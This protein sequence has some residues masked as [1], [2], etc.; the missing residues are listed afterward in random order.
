[1]LPTTTGEP[2]AYQTAWPD[3]HLAARARRSTDV[4]LLSARYGFRKAVKK[5]LKSYGDRLR[6][7]LFTD[8]ADEASTVFLLSSG[9]SGST[10]LSEMLQS[11]PSTRTIFEPF[12]ATRGYPAL[13]DHRYRY[14]PPGQEDAPLRETLSDVLAGRQRSAW[15]DQFNPLMPTTFRRRLVKEV[16]ANLLSPWLTRALPAARFLFLVRHPIP[17]AL[18]QLK[19]GWVLSSQRLR[20]QAELAD[21]YGLDR[22]SRF[23]WPTKGFES[24]VLFWAIENLVALDCAERSGSLLVRY[25]DLVLRPGASLAT[26]GQHIGVEFPDQVR[27]TFSETSWSS[28][29]GVGELSPAEKVNRWQRVASPSQ[30][31]FVGAVLTASELGGL[32]A[33][34]GVDV[35]AR[36][37]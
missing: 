37:V 22:F 34:D 23:G 12:H 35:T 28:R 11:V 19:G 29:R 7:R 26:I 6:S 31:D 14:L 13:A 24:L 15:S 10:W 1:M 18:S 33:A 17:L 27:E 32:Y 8:A 9:R 3:E 4:P 21:R 16:R 20:E 25:E 5:R 2:P 36:G 30:V